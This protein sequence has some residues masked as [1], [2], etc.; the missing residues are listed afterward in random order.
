MYIYINIYIYIH[1]INAIPHNAAFTVICGDIPVNLLINVHLNYPIPLLEY[2][3]I[4]VH[5]GDVWKSNNFN[6][7][8]F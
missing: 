3:N 8:H 7:I 4:A 1:N 6:T 5:L 2:T